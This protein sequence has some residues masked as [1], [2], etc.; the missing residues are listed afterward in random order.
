MNPTSRA[1]KTILVVDDCREIRRMIRRLLGADFECIEA[2]SL[3]EAS[4]ALA[5]REVDVVLLDLVL[6]DANAEETLAF[7]RAAREVRVVTMSG[8][9][10][11]ALEVT[12]LPI[13][14]GRHVSKPFTFSELV[15][16]L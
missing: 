10:S 12:A 7:A 4:G 11:D 8:L 15:T 13:P 5:S 9:T 3:S 16:H 2:A 6:T 1:R 14:A